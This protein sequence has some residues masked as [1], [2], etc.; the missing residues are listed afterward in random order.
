MRRELKY[1]TSHCDPGA[2]LFGR[3]GE[4]FA[5]N[6]ARGNLKLNRKLHLSNQCWPFPIFN[7]QRLQM[8]FMNQIDLTSLLNKFRK[9]ETLSMTLCK[10]RTRCA[11][12]LLQQVEN[13]KLCA[14]CMFESC[15]TNLGKRKWQLVNFL[16]E[17]D[18]SPL[19]MK[20]HVSRFQDRPAF[21]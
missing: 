18:I 4:K 19:E 3:R 9:K 1:G 15:S 7:Y 10:L 12:F 6:F 5:Q 11:P 8:E 17:R 21:I 14:L 20:V 13:E 16:A 2:L